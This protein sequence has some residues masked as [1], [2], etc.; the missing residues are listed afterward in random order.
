[1]G[2]ATDHERPKADQPSAI[3]QYEHRIRD[4]ER[5]VGHQEG[6][7]ALLKSFLAGPSLRKN[8]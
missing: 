1:M 6:E 7:I 3:R 2:H 8:A 4:R 5:L